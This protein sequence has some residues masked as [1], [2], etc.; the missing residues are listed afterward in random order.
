MNRLVAGQHFG[1]VSSQIRKTRTDSIISEE[2]LHLA[3]IHAADYLEIFSHEINTLNF[4][5]NH[6]I[7]TLSHAIQRAQIINIAYKFEEV[8]Y[9]YHQC[10]F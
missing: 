1:E 4:I 10:I 8:Q 2:E 5:Q 3:Y 9:D 7:S 6:L